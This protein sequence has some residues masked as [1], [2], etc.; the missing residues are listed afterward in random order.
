MLTQRIVPSVLLFTFFFTPLVSAASATF[1]FKDPKGVNTIAFI[2]DST[3]EPIMGLA[4]GI[5]G[6]VSFDPA[7]PKATTGKIVVQTK[8]LH[9]ENKGMKDSMHSDDWLDAAKNP[10]IEFNIK[11]VADAKSSEKD[12]HELTVVGE[13]TIKGVTKEVTAPVKVT[14]LAGKMSDRTK[15]KGDLLVVRSNFTIKRSDFNIKPDMGDKVVANDIELRVSIVGG[16]AT[17]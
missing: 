7:D 14:Y 2:L 17:K 5:S 1:D 9:T 12:V 10:T 8:S 15:A 4:S 6:T 3:L 16:A 13:L 11:K